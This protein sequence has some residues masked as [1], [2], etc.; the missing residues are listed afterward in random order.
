MGKEVISV[1]T[2]TIQNM[3]KRL[4]KN[5]AK[6]IILNAEDADKAADMCIKKSRE[7]NSKKGFFIVRQ[8]RNIL[9]KKFYCFVKVKKN[10]IRMIKNGKKCSWNCMNVE[11]DI[12]KYST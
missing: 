9:K 11:Y 3:D 1:G 12:K 6:R 5:G 7:M 4:N 10:M 2:F 8:S